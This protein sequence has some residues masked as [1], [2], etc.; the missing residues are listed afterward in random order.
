MLHRKWQRQETIKMIDLCKWWSSECN[1]NMTQR[2]KN[3]RTMKW[4]QTC[5]K[6]IIRTKH[7]SWC[8]TKM[9]TVEL[10]N[11]EHNAWT[12]SIKLSTKTLQEWRSSFNVRNPKRLDSRICMRQKREN[13]WI[14]IRAGM[15][16]K[17]SGMQCKNR[18]MT[19]DLRRQLVRNKL[20]WLECNEQWM[21]RGKLLL[22]W[23]KPSIR[24]R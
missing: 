14:K 1:S 24:I 18:V 11:K 21:S 12:P 20:W 17:H 2:C 19:I 8:Q 13:E 23:K 6:S 22:I 15:T 10:E 5:N 4:N 7:P 3:K 9:I 16:K